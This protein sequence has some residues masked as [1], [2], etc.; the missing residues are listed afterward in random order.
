[1][2]NWL[3]QRLL[4]ALESTL[5]DDGSPSFDD[6]QGMFFDEY[7]RRSIGTLRHLYETDK[8]AFKIDFGRHIEERREQRPHEYI[9]RLV[10]HVVKSR[11]KIPCLIF[12]N[13]DHFTIE[14][15]EKVFQYARSV[16]ESEVCLVIMPITDR[17]SWQLSNE[18]ALRSFESETL[19]LPTPSPKAILRKRVQ[20]LQTRLAEEE[21]EPG[22][23]YFFGRGIPMALGDLTAFA[24]AL[25]AVFLET[26]NVAWWIGNFAN[27]DIRRCLEIAKDLVTS[28]HLEVHELVKG[29]IAYSSVQVPL[30]KIKRALIRG[31]YNIYPEGLH[32]FIRNIYALD[33]ETDTSPLIGVRIL[34]LLRDAKKSDGLNPFITTEQV[35]EYFRAM[36]V[37]PS[38]TE[39][40]LGKMLATALCLSYDPTV[41]EV[42]RAGG[43]ELSLSG[44][45]HLKWATGDRDYIQS[46]R[47]VT[48][49]VD[50][51]VFETL[52]ELSH[53]KHKE[54]WTDRLVT[55]VK[56]LV[57]EDAKF[58]RPPDHQAYSSQH[59]LA[60]ELYRMTQPQSSGSRTHGVNG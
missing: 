7:R 56:Y 12:D 16:Y 46:M 31:K 28:P 19:F 32:S 59:R 6:L 5:F 10:Q 58:C 41:T 3:D 4:A 30:Y 48:P 13:A 40:W 49:L 17:T 45:Q 53:Q 54:M 26:G 43:I 21:H 11:R 60:S 27:G 15:Q 14:F 1:M 36:L 50:M 55:F 44:F 47:E 42:K 2:V 33:E 8:S 34:Q 57:D 18:G 22:K 38:V 24:A 29:Y 25:Q 9:H 39:A 35:T 20:F 51:A 37:E 23:G 52:R